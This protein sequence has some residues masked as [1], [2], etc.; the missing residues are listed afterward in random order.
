M[1]DDLVAYFAGYNSMSLGRVKKLY[2]AWARA[3]GPHSSQCQELNRLFSQCVDGNK[4]KIPRHFEQDPPDPSSLAEPFILDTL[5]D[6][7]LDYCRKVK[8]SSDNANIMRGPLSLLNIAEGADR[9]MMEFI[10][11]N[12]SVFSDFELAKLTLNWCRKNHVPFEE[13]WTYF[14]PSRFSV[15]E[16]AWILSELPPSAKYASYVKNGLLQSNILTRE[17]LETF[18]LDFHSFHWKC[19]FDSTSDPLRKLMAMVNQTFSQF[20]K[21]LLILRLGERL[22]IAIYF[23]RPLEKEE[24]SV[25]HA[26]VR[27]FAFPHS[28]KD[29]VGHRRAVPT[30]KNY[31]FYYD[32]TMMQLYENHRSNTFVYFGTPGEND[33]SYRG[34]EGKNNRARARQETID[35]GI[36][37]DWIVSVAL[38]KFSAQLATQ[39]GR[40]KGTPV[41][42]AV[43]YAI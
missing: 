38:Q 23:P 17:D 13:F 30:K 32:D 40:T 9:E 36:N 1:R 37:S 34:V 16:Q 42:E 18:R 15:D 21:K 6:L 24:D 27:L 10:L 14:D 12:P 8:A 22:S 29:K 35:A 19:V 7:A 33:L 43:R 25:V 26:T 41:T 5:H 28:H 20:A 4:I 2:L 39:I 11:S 3:K 31:R